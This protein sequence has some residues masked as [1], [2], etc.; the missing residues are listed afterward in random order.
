VDDKKI[1][2]LPAGGVL[3]VSH[4]QQYCSPSVMIILVQLIYTVSA[5]LF[6]IPDVDGDVRIFVS[7]S[8]GEGV[9]ALTMTVGTSLICNRKEYSGPH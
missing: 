1:L 6:K 7:E 4:I 5:L 9:A 2:V 3:Y 8:A